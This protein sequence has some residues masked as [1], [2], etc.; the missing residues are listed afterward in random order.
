MK[1]RLGLLRSREF[2][3]KDLYTFDTTLD[4]AESTYNLVCESYN[5]I[6]GQIGIKYVK[7]NYL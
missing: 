3:M 7:G 6:F 1:P 2:I 4:N 5:K